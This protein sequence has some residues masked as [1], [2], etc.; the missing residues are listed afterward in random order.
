M[1]LF[2]LLKKAS[3]WK[4]IVYI[5]IIYLLFVLLGTSHVITVLDSIDG[6]QSDQLCFL[7]FSYKRRG[8]KI[9][10]KTQG[11][12]GLKQF[13]EAGMTIPDYRT[14]PRR[15]QAMLFILDSSV[16]PALIKMLRWSEQRVVILTIMYYLK[17]H[18]MTTTH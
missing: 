10:R 16:E 12:R 11:L 2:N 15:Y 13:G 8:R 1:T 5:A 9:K 17:L 7:F 6:E 3:N 18:E 14:L 4:H